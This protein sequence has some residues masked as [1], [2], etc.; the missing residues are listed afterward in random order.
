MHRAFGSTYLSLFHLPALSNSRGAGCHSSLL[1]SLVPISPNTRGFFQCRQS[2]WTALAGTR[3]APRLWWGAVLRANP[4][5][6]GLRV[7]GPFVPEQLGDHLWSKH[8]LCSRSWVSHTTCPLSWL[9][10]LWNQGNGSAVRDAVQIWKSQILG[11]DQA[12]H[13]KDSNKKKGENSQLFFPY[14]KLICGIF[15][16]RLLFQDKGKR[17]EGRKT[18]PRIQT[19]FASYCINFFFFLKLQLSNKSSPVAKIKRVGWEKFIR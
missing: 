10:S 14:T 15:S 17:R 9:S 2:L 18:L 12:A 3:C 13:S 19:E 8:A 16:A 1:F 4:G 7:G 11:G 5:E 6:N